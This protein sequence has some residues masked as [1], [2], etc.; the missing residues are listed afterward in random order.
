M[1]SGENSDVQQTSP[2]IEQTRSEIIEDGVI[3]CARM[4]DRDPIVDACRAALRG[5]LRVLEITLTTPG[6]LRAIETLAK[7]GDAIVGP[8]PS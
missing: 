6:A 2:A 3:L 7:G 5:G 8:G 1:T 4:G